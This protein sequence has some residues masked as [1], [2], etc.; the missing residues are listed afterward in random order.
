MKK[1]FTLEKKLTS[2][3]A[4][5]AAL[6]GV[7]N[8]NGQVAYTN[9]DP[10]ETI[11]DT[12][13]NLD[14]DG[15]AVVDYV[16]HERN[17]TNGVQVQQDVAMVNAIRGLAGGNY[18]YPNVLNMG[19]PIS[20]GQT[21]FIVH[22]QQTLNWQGCAFT[23]SQW[24]NGVVDKYLGLRFEIGGNTH[25]GW[26]RLDVPADGSSFTIKDYAYNVTPNAPITAGEGLGVEDLNSN[27]SVSLISPNPAKDFV[28]VRLT[29]T[30]DSERTQIT[31]SDLSG[32]QV[33]SAAYTEEINVSSLEK[34]VY[35]MT[36]TDGNE[37]ENQ[38]LIKE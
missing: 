8:A 11:M 17:G 29:E 12:D 16:L 35:V 37:I 22:A 23:N 4:F 26:A 10:D 36:I 15:D 13:Y 19:D 31:I 32:K 33:L 7:A 5:A 14:L 3:G 2:Y 24:C 25:Y 34:G 21:D 28:S 38:K 1:F 30:F 27:T 20:S 18:N 9:V 6:A